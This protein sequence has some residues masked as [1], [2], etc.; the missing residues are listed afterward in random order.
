MSPQPTPEELTTWHRWFAVTCN[1]RAWD[2]AE[3]ASRTPDEAQQMLNMAYAAAYHWS[4]VGAPVNAARAD[5]TLAHMLALCGQGALAQ[6]HAERA[7][8]YFAQ[9]PAEDWDDAYVALELAFA[10]A[11][12]GQHAAHARHYARARSLAE[13]IADADDREVVLQTLARIPAP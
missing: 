11:A 12:Q 1:N 10:A 9:F 7:Q 5:I 8:A 2:L 13:A 6:H 3:R 4:Q